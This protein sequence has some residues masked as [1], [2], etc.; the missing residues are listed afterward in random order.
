VYQKAGFRLVEDR[1]NFM[2]GRDLLSQTW[3]L[4]LTESGAA[5]ISLAT[6]PSS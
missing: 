4:D 1:A 6:E 5:E 2:F 3:E